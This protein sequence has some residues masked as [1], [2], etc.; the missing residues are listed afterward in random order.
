MKNQRSK[1]KISILKNSKENRLNENPSL[2]DYYLM[3][4]FHQLMKV[5][6]K[7]TTET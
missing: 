1:N 4:A 5:H 2:D 3:K 6:H 7:I